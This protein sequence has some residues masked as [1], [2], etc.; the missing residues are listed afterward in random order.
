MSTDV[1]DDDDDDFDE[2]TCQVRRMVGLRAGNA[3]A[4]RI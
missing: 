3:F 1:I 4:R 2:E